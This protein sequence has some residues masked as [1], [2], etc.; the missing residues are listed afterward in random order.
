MSP[1]IPIRL[2]G[3]F[4]D[5]GHIRDKSKSDVP[6]LVAVRFQKLKVD[7]RKWGSYSDP[8]YLITHQEELCHELRK[9]YSR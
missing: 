9:I 3:I 7:A 1:L 5:L 2:E 6:V 8:E 4:R